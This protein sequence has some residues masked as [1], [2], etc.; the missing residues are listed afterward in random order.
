[1]ENNMNSVVHPTPAAPPAGSEEFSPGKVGLFQAALSEAPPSRFLAREGEDPLTSAFDRKVAVHAG[2]GG[3]PVA[4]ADRESLLERLLDMPRR[5]PS[6]LYIHVPF[7]ETHCLYCG[8]YNRAYRPEE[9]ARYTDALLREMD[10]W[11]ARP[12]ARSGPFH[13]VYL[14]GGTPTALEAADLRRILLAV[15][16]GFPLANDCEITVE[17]RIHHF[18]AEKMDACLSAGAN[19]FSLGVQTFH[20]ALRRSMNRLADR[21]SAIRALGELRDDGRAGVVVDLIY[22]FPGQTRDMWRRDLEDFLA[23]EIDGV[24]L[25]QLNVFRD[26]PLDKAI[27]AGKSPAAADPPEQARLFEAGVARLGR[28]RYRRLSIS[29]WGRT[30]RERNV[31]NHLMKGPSECLAFGPGA[32]GCLGGHYYFGETRYDRWIEGV[33]AGRKPLSMLA[34]PHPMAALD[35]TLAAGFDLGRVHLRG[36]GESFGLPLETRLAP[37]AEQWRRAGLVDLDEGWMELTLAGQFWSVNLAQFA[38]EHLH[39]RQEPKETA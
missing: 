17:G 31:Y 35:K 22:G 38:I 37:L 36:I 14:G 34:A 39:R 23:L 26:S 21:A 1:M 11:R 32:G 6:A 28:A 4:E 20:T 16:D 24:D 2:F 18:D 25:Y 8:F 10:L 33:S 27:Q 29:H 5:G 30:T 13:A 3:H 19:R 15:R 12:A 9:S 7:C